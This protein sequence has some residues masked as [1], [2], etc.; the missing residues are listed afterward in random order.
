MTNVGVLALQGDVREHLH[1]LESLGGCDTGQDPEPTRF[2]RRA[3]DPGRGV[4]HDRQ[5]GRP[6]RPPEL[7]RRS[8]EDG[9]PPTGRA[10]LILMAGAVTDGDQPLLGVLDVVVRRNAFGR[11]NESFES[12]LEVDGLEHTFPRGLHPSPMGREGGP[13]SRSWQISTSTPSWF[14]RATSSPPRSTRS[15]PGM[16]ESTNSS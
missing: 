13:K 15:S 6:L 16:G 10:G 7:L 8:I 11:Q 5:D 14:A 1:T 2:G 12:D 3:R 4:D 9:L